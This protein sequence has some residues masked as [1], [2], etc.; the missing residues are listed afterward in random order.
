MT[1]IDQLPHQS[2]HET[3]I[4]RLKRTLGLGAASLMLFPAAAACSTEAESVDAKIPTDYEYVDCRSA[5][6]GDGS[7]D[8]LTGAAQRA[9][10]KLERAYPEAGADITGI[11]RDIAVDQIESQENALDIGNKAKICLYKTD[12]D[13]GTSHYVVEGSG[14]DVINQGS[15]SN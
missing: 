2:D 9:I 10:E 5:I 7:S 1:K 11:D 13:D 6:V 15:R 8:W 3:K 4:S 14:T 12:N